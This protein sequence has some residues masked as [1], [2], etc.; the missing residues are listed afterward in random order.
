ML[1][2]NM[3]SRRRCHLNCNPPCIHICR[4]VSSRL[5]SFTAFACIS[6][7]FNILFFHSISSQIAQLFPK[8]INT[9]FPSLTLTE[10]YRH[11]VVAVPLKILRFTE[12]DALKRNYFEK[13]QHLVF[14]VVVDD[15]FCPDDV[16]CIELTSQMGPRLRD[17]AR[18]SARGEWEKPRKIVLCFSS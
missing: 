13:N 1:H 17:P 15:A 18:C 12:T 14:V 6:F 16:V 2:F 10:S 4:F 3:F 11:T 9:R 8:K 5:S 7:A